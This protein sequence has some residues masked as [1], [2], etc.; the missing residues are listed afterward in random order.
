MSLMNGALLRRKISDNNYQDHVVDKMV[1]TVGRSK[2]CDV[3]INDSSL[4]RLHMRIEHREGQFYVVDNNS[5][6]GTFV[7]RRKIVDAPIRNGDA[8][9][10]GRLHFVFECRGDDAGEPTRPMTSIDGIPVADE[11]VT[12]TLD[13][14]ASEESLV[15]PP[16]MD[17]PTDPPTELSMSESETYSEAL[18]HPPSAVMVYERAKPLTRLLAVCIDA[19]VGFALMLPGMVASILFGAT[20]GGMVS[21]LG[22]LASLAHVVVGWLKYGRTIGKHVMGIQI[23]KVPEEEGEGLDPKTVVLRLVVMMACCIPLCLP[24][25]LIFRDPKG[26]GLHDKVAATSVVRRYP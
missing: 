2:S 16:L 24:F 15:P 13:D 4:S 14:Y 19:G 9:I 17:L 1:T 22:S 7:N 18:T 8:V 23:V 10:A 26:R 5:S 20:F 21:M 25:L 6:N 12:A 11:T 3:T